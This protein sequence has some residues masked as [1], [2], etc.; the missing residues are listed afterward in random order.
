MLARTQKSD[1]SENRENR[2]IYENNS[3][4]PVIR[5]RG[6]MFNQIQFLF[7]DMS[8]RNKTDDK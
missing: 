1:F 5:R 7:V 3:F 8:P 4:R 2:L 6:R